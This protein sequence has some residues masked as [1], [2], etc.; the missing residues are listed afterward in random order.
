V[1]GLKGGS[2]IIQFRRTF[3]RFS[4]YYAVASVIFLGATLFMLPDWSWENGRFDSIIDGAISVAI[5]ITSAFLL[6][7]QK[8]NQEKISGLTLAFL[9]TGVL[10]F[11]GSAIETE[12]ETVWLHRLCSLAIGVAFFFESLPISKPNSKSK[13]LTLTLMLTL[14]LALIIGFVVAFFPETLPKLVIASRATLPL[15]LVSLASAFIFFLAAGL[16]W[17]E[18]PTLFICCLFLGLPAFL[19]PVFP[20]WTI[21]WWVFQAI[22]LAV[23]SY[24]ASSFFIHHYRQ[25]LKTNAASREQAKM[26]EN[27]LALVS[28][29]IRN[30]LG[31]AIMGSQM[32]LKSSG[33]SDKDHTLLKR[34]NRNLK[35][36]DSM[37][38]TL[39]DVA[40]ERKVKS[41]PLE[42]QG[43]D[44]ATEVARII[45]CQ[46]LV[47]RDHIVLTLNESIWGDWGVVG[48]H[49]AL[50]NLVTNAVKYGEPNTLIHVK[51]RRRNDL[52]LLSVHNQGPEIPVEDQEKIFQAFQRS[53]G[54]N[55][56]GTQ[57]WGLG[58]ALVKGIAEAHCGVVK[59]ESAKTE[60][61]TFTLELPI[62]TYH[63]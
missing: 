4:R 19:Y 27:T 37:I 25:I 33:M 9:T 16:R 56:S 39:L 58:L 3:G 23:N 26:M 30:P 29:D 42:F 54:S 21:Q 34:M 61:T 55:H 17:R 59:L 41:M 63:S 62:Q 2:L 31:V 47:D 22:E 44:L 35:F 38:Q 11:L 1:T 28:H 48:I 51:L 6:L 46:T 5:F 60:G 13:P 18:S 15:A 43:C 12:D 45:E 7:S 20:I 53:A 50:D 8:L 32:L 14:V 10:R 57:G 52:A 49:R 36:I 40:R 24:L